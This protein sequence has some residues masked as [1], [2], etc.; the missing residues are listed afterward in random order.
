MGLPTALVVLMQGA[1]SVP[2][3][4]SQFPVFAPGFSKEAVGLFISFVHNFALTV[5]ACS[6]V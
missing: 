4:C 3:F 5:H 2:C 6:Y 1:C